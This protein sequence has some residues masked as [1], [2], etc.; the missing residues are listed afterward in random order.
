MVGR[1]L[2]RQGPRQ[3]DHRGGAGGAVVGADESLRVVLGV[4]VGA[5]QD[6][7]ARRPGATPTMFRRP[8]WGPL[9]ATGSNCPFGSS[10]RSFSASCRS[11]GEP[12]GRWPD[13]DLLLD[14]RERPIG[15]EAVRARLESPPPP[16]PASAS[17][18]S[19]SA[20][21]RARPRYAACLPLRF[22]ARLGADRGHRGLVMAP[23]TIPDHVGLGD[24]LL[25]RLGLDLAPREAA[26]RAGRPSGRG[27]APRARPPSAGPRCSSE[28]ST[29]LTTS[30]CLSLSRTTHIAASSTGPRFR[31]S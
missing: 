18:G 10:A 30:S 12:A 15:V 7:R 22:G 14:Q 20:S 28:R 17:A 8:C 1:Q 9:P 19:A 16:Q 21:E 23:A 26:P 3:L 13:R 29:A 25:G 24:S 5:D 4:V 31:A 6:R 11:A 27:R 2:R